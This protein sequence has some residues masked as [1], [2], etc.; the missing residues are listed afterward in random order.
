M[1]YLLLLRRFEILI[2]F[3]I[4]LPSFGRYQK[5]KKLTERSYGPTGWHL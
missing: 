4:F 3:L 5:W 2:M 1:A